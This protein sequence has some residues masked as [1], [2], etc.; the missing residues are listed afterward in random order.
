MLSDD[1]RLEA[2]R[3]QTSVAYAEAAKLQRRSRVVTRML[4]LLVVALVIAVAA[5]SYRMLRLENYVLPRNSTALATPRPIAPRTALS[6]GEK[7]RIGLFDRTWRSVVHITTLAVRTD[8]FRL[9]VMEVP[10]GSGSGFVWDAHGHVVTNF[11]V[12]AGADEAKI[13]FADKTT[14]NARLVGQSARNDIAVLRVVGLPNNVSPLAVGT[15]Q[16]LVVGQDVIAI[17]SPFG[18]DYTLSTGVISGLGR[19]IMGAGGL[20]IGGVI[21]T[22]AA[23]NPGNSGGPLMDSAGRLIG[24]NTAILSPSGASAGVGFAVPVDTVARVVP[25]LIAYGRE[26]RPEIGVVL[27]DDS[28]TERF[29][30]PGVLVLGVAENSPASKVG[31]QPTQRTPTGDIVLGDVIHQVDG[32]DIRKTADLLLQLEKHKAGDTITISVVRE[33]KPTALSVVLASNVVGDRSNA[34]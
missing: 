11:H 24:V 9:N 31:M 6:S 28:V 29:S 23:I 22:D 13:T 7:E 19:E 26:I 5:L 21:Q 12:I 16:D 33:G 4:T 8:P 25:Q 34:F 27:A 1:S 20:P 2:A 18:L 17:G 30:L 10:R 15:S 3:A 14:V 32:K